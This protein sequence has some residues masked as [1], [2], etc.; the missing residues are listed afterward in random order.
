MSLNPFKSTTDSLIGASG[1][2]VSVFTKTLTSLTANTEQLDVHDGTLESRQ[3]EIQAQ[4]NAIAKVKATNEKMASK[5][6]EFLGVEEVT[7][8]TSDVEEVKG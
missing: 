2:I 8:S 4:R 1:N 5:I 7:E 3:A 6:E